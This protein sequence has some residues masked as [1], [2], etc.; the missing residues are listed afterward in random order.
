MK[1]ISLILSILILAGTCLGFSWT[2]S[3]GTTNATDLTDEYW[4]NE[5]GDFMTG[6]LSI[7]TNLIL[8]NTIQSMQDSDTSISFNSDGDEIILYCSG[9]NM[10]NLVGGAAEGDIK[11]N[12]NLANWDFSVNTDTISNFFFVDAGANRIGINRSTSP[13]H[14]LDVNGNISGKNYLNGSGDLEWIMPE[15]IYDVDDE[16]I[17]S[18]LNTYVDIAGDEMTGQFNV[19]GANA[20]FTERICLDT[21]CAESLRT[22]ST[23]AIIIQGATSAIYIN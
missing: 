13:S 18:D 22:N 2:G 8:N 6:N 11:F 15:N 19:T 10:L 1:Y 16:D 4:V 20:T 12:T 23:G 14:M 21:S 7:D 9:F 17:E 5:S 3:S